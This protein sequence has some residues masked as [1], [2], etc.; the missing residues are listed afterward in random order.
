MYQRILN[1]PDRIQILNGL[2]KLLVEWSNRAAVQ[3]QRESREARVKKELGEGP[4]VIDKE[5]LLL[6]D[7]A[8]IEAVKSL[9][10][11]S[12]EFTRLNFYFIAS[13]LFRRAG[14]IDGSRKCGAVLTKAFK[15][16]EGKSPIDEASIWACSS[17]LNS[18]AYGLIP[19]VIPDIKPTSAQ[20]TSFTK[21]EFETC[22]KLKLRAV[23]MT[24]RLDATN[25][26]RRKAHRDLSLWYSQLGKTELADKQK[27]TLLELVGTK[28]DSILYP[29]VQMCGHLVWW[30]VVPNYVLP[31]DNCGM[32]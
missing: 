2:D 18:E 13:R 22:E 7:K 26:L 27:Q 31:G 30:Q 8:L 24:D 16:S 23:S 29:H 3:E 10:Q 4:Q 11:I 19:I 17:I 28:N 15:S 9:E 21:E 25:H 1:E 5:D 14:D 12:D 20:A 32:G 6:A